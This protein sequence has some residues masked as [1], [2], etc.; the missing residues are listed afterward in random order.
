LQAGVAARKG[1]AAVSDKAAVVATTSSWR[2]L[3]LGWSWAV[4]FMIFSS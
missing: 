1:A 4:R 2:C 3:V